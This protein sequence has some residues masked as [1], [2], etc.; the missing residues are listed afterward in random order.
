VTVSRSEVRGFKSPVT[1]RHFRNHKL[2]TNVALGIFVTLFPSYSIALA[3]K[4][5]QNIIVRINFSKLKLQIPEKN[6]FIGPKMQ[7]LF[8]FKPSEDYLLYILRV[9]T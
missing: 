2:I 6:I 1:H 3:K 9:L 8:T 4:T 7:R 5:F